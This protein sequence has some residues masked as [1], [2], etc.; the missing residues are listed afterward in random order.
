M[1]DGVLI[2]TG[3]L[4]LLLV[5]GVAGFLFDLLRRHRSASSHEDAIQRRASQTLRYYRDVG[6]STNAGGM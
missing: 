3:V 2:V 4:G 5:L 1:S 6:D